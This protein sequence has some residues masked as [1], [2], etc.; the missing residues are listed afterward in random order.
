MLEK[1]IERIAD[2]L[3]IIAGVM[4][5]KAENS[6]AAG[7]P[8][9]KE[10]VEVPAPVAEVIAEMAEK[11]ITAPEVIAAQEAAVPTPPPAPVTTVPP[12]VEPLPE[13]PT[14]QM[15]LEELNQGLVT[16][17]HRLGSRDMID[18][19][20]KGFGVGSANELAPDSYAEVLRDV[21]AIK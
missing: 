11:P 12:P 19:T 2:A 16:E 3:E 8:L 7:V 17:F 1:N 9:K 18:A 5:D 4:D 20:I 15:T 13:A 14:V 6:Y 10:K 21:Q